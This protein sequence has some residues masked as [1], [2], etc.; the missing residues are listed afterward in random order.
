MQS[1]ERRW[2]YVL[3]ADCERLWGVLIFLQH[4][5]WSETLDTECVGPG[6]SEPGNCCEYLP[7]VSLCSILARFFR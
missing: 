2:E 1:C 6:I 4:I 3:V 7:H 5:R